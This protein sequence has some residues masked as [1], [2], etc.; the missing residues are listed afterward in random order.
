MRISPSTGTM[1][2]PTAAMKVISIRRL[3]EN[4][5]PHLPLRDLL[6]AQ[7]ISKFFYT[8][9][10][11]SRN[12]KRALFLTP[13]TQETISWHVSPTAAYRSG[14]GSWQNTSQGA[15]IKPLLNPSSCVVS[16]PPP[17]LSFYK[18]DNARNHPQRPR[19]AMETLRRTGNPSSEYGQKAPTSAKHPASHS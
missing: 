13:S 3:L 10:Q 8:F 5:L 18:E 9:I 14:E 15:A 7:K 16:I 19:L 12:I 6:L 11:K 1:E 17:P 4:I 2:A